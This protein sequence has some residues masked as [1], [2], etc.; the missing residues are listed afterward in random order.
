V[1]TLTSNGAEACKLTPC[2]TPLRA[3]TGRSQASAP[4]FGLRPE[5][6]LPGAEQASESIGCAVPQGGPPAQPA[7]PG[8]AGGPVAI[9]VKR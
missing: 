6:V 2:G 9:A 1:A 5:Y 3:A 4:L 7:A 8:P